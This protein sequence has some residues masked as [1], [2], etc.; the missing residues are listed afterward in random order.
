[1]LPVHHKLLASLVVLQ[2]GFPQYGVLWFEWQRSVEQFPWSLEKVQLA[3]VVPLEV[4]VELW[5]SLAG[6]L[7]E[8][9]PVAC[10]VA[11]KSKTSEREV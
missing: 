11:I 8:E 1:M 3:V 4:E 5:L 7:W 6:K 2:C 10:V 9:C